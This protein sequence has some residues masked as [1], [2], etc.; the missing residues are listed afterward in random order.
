MGRH[1]SFR[2]AVSTQGQ[3]ATGGRRA[4]PLTSTRLHSPIACCVAAK[5]GCKAAALQRALWGDYAYQ[6][7]TKRIVRIK[8]DQAGRA[9]PLF[10]QLAL[11]PIWKVSGSWGA[12]SRG[13]LGGR[14][15]NRRCLIPAQ[16]TQT[17]N[18]VDRLSC[19]FCASRP[20]TIPWHPCPH[21]LMQAYSACEQGADHTAILGRMVQGLGLAGMTPR[22]LAHPDPRVALRSVLR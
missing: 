2:R 14:G 10:V 7:K 16:H 17:C 4:S 1:G 12:R 22:M 18:M 11:E 3:S 15:S 6:P 19:A 9:K 13:G 8:S 20:P 21:L 5:M